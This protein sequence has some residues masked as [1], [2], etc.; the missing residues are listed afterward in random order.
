[1]NYVDIWGRNL[2]LNSYKHSFTWVILFKWAAILLKNWSYAWS[3]SCIKT[4]S[5]LEFTVLREITLPCLK[6]HMFFLYQ[7]IGR[8]LLYSV[9][10]TLLGPSLIEY[11]IS[12]RTLKDPSMPKSS[13][14]EQCQS[15]ISILPFNPSY[16]L[17]HFLILVWQDL[18]LIFTALSNT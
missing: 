1:M 4:H 7:S 3:C 13:P 2:M 10:S 12:L 18:L 6:E 9:S 11:R 8:I 16:Q 14:Y 5:R 15:D 17:S